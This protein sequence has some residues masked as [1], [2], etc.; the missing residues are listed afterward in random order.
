MSSATV[1]DAINTAVTA[2]AVPWPT[3]DVS[4]YVTLEECLG[5]V[6]SQCVLIQYAASSESIVTIGSEGNQ[7]FVESGSVVLHMVTPTGFDSGPIVTKADEIRE[8]LRGRRVAPSVTV[9]QMDPFT[10]FG[11]GMGLYGA[12]WHGWGANLIY[13]RRDCG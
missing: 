7:G 2:A 13:V 11:I 12:A 9:E 3:F 5:N 10:D 6:D 8:A 1:R 4:D